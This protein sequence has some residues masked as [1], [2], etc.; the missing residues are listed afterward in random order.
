MKTLTYQ[1]FFLIVII[2]L[3]N[4]KLIFAQKFTSEDYVKNHIFFELG[5][6]G[7][8]YSINYERLVTK[9]FSLRGGFGFWFND[10]IGLGTPS[11]TFYSVPIT[12]SY[13]I[14]EEH[15]KFELGLG[16]AFFAAEDATI[17][18]VNLG[19][20]S[21]LV[22]TTIIGFRGSSRDGGFVF[23][24]AFTP[25]FSTSSDLKFYPYGGVSFGHS[26]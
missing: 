9:N 23:R 16:A 4:S 21:D 3:L 1:L 24:I 26:F 5:G 6:N 18:F 15:S 11:G 20:Q 17:F 2:Q 12:A 22:V 7:F 25:F 8:L 10:D 19:D 14:G 13:L